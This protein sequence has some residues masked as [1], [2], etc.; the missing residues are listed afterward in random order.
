MDRAAA[1]FFIVAFLPEFRHCFTAPGFH[2]FQDFVLAYWLGE[3]HRTVTAVWR[4]TTGRRHFSCFHRFLVTYRWSP[5]AVA[6]RLLTVALARLGI[7][8]GADGKLW[9]TLAADDTLVRKFGR[10]LEGAGWQHDA[11][12]P[13]PKAPIA[14]GQCFVVVGLLAQTHGRWRCFPFAAWLFRPAKSAGAPQTQETKL[15]LLA[16]RL[17]ELQLPSTWRLRLVADTAYGKRP[18]AEA[19]WEGNH[20][21]VSRLPSNSVVFELPAPPDP[22]LK[23]RGAKKQYGRK[24]ALGHFATL[25]AAAEPVSRDLYGQR[26]RVRI[27]AQRVRSRAL[28]GCVILLV[29]VIRVSKGGKESRPTYLFSTDLSLSADAVVELYAARFQIELA[30]RELKNYY[31][32]GH[33]QARRTGAAERHVQLCLVS[34]LGSQ[35]YAAVAAPAGRGE[36]WR[37]AP[38]IATTG[39]LRAAAQRERQAQITIAICERH[40][41]PEEKRG[42]IYADLLLAA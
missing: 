37:I 18:L 31:G 32:F 2:H 28:G 5:N 35:L 22:A 8:P 20:C 1:L 41:I 25:A 23:R 40:G 21:L 33:C 15:A 29:T 14:F 4:S 3:G 9:L 38:A 13:S 34:Y 10:R 42:V 24:R 6:Q 26:W 11:M 12:A 17:R 27:Y 16:R 7:A 30:F 39:Q 19:L 36:P